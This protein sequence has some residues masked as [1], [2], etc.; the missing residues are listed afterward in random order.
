MIRK[1]LF[2]F[3]LF[4]ILTGCEENQRTLGGF[5]DGQNCIT[6]EHCLAGWECI[7]N[8]CKIKCKEGTQDNNNDGICNPDCNTAE[9]KCPENQKVIGCDDSSGIAIP[10]CICKSGFQDNDGN[11]TCKRNCSDWSV[12]E[13][14]VNQEV[15]KCNDST[16]SPVYY[17]QCMAGYQDNDKNGE[18]L[19]DCNTK[20]CSNATCDDSTGVA[21]CTCKDGY[22]Q[23]DGVTDGCE[24]DMV[25]VPA[26]NFMMG[27][28]T[29]VDSHCDDDEDPYHE[30]YLDAY[31]IDKYEVTVRDFRKCVTVGACSTDNFESKWN[32]NHHRELHPMN[33]VNWYGAKEYCEWLGKRLPTEAEWEKAARGDDGRL[34]PWGSDVIDC[35]YATFY[36]DGEDGCGTDTTSVVGSKPK[37]VSVYG[38]YDMSGN[39]WEWANDWYGKSYYTSELMTNPEGPAT[40]NYRVVHGGGW[41][42]NPKKL[43]LSNRYD[44]SPDNKDIDTGFRCAKSL[45]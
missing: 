24:E 30:V 22:I 10:E 36:Y 1:L 4:L 25:T 18:C 5:K 27:C 44:N 41:D 9:L 45:D 20:I 31:K 19:E 13:C 43:R 23:I 26:G 21:V 28:N 32:Y 3:I 39:V 6:N 29:E 33:G 40:G 38:V 14:P 35:E 8:I 16:G 7:D 12:F 37:G 42:D 15:F 2:I 17:C 11:Y 34:Y